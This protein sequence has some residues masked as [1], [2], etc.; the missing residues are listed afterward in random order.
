MKRVKLTKLWKLSLALFISLASIG[1][2]INSMD[3][4][5]SE[6]FDINETITMNEESTQATITLDVSNIDEKYTIQSIQNPDGSVMDVVNDPSYMVKEN[7]L[8]TFVVSYIDTTSEE[9]EELI[10]NKEV[11]VT[12]IGVDEQKEEM[13]TT[14]K[15]ESKQPK[16]VTNPS[17][18]SLTVEF[19]KDGA[20]NV[21]WSDASQVDWNF[22][23]TEKVVIT[24]V[25]SGKG[26]DKVREIDIDIP[27][28]YQIIG[29]SAKS[30][31]TSQNGESILTTTE[32]VQQ[33]M[34]T[35]VLT[36]QNGGAF[37]S[38]KVDGYKTTSNVDYTEANKS[39]KI[40]YTFNSDADTVVL[41]LQLG[42]DKKLYD[43][44]DT[45]EEYSDAQGT[46]SEGTSNGKVLE[47]LKVTQTSGSQVL[48]E[49][50]NANVKKTIESM[51]LHTDGRQENIYIDDDGLS[52]NFKPYGKQIH[53]GNTVN[54]FNMMVDELVITYNYPEGAQFVGMPE[55]T[56]FSKAANMTY[57]DDPVSRTLTVTYTNF[58]A[59]GPIYDVVQPLFKLDGDVYGTD[60]I[61]NPTATFTS[62]MAT[63]VYG[64]ENYY[65]T[66]SSFVTNLIDKDVPLT[67]VGYDQKVYDYKLN[68]YEDGYQFLGNYSV[69]N[70]S[71]VNKEDIDLE[72][73]FDSS[74]GIRIVRLALPTGTKISDVKI[75]TTKSPSGI[76]LADMKSINSTTG[77]G[78]IIDADKLG[79]DNDDYIT[80]VEGVIDSY[81]AQANNNVAWAMK[82]FGYCAYGSIQNGSGGSHTLT[83]D[84]VTATSNITT[85]PDRI[86]NGGPV[87][88]NTLKG[89]YYPGDSISVQTK[90]TTY[91]NT[92]NRSK[93]V[94]DDFL[95]DPNVY[96]RVPEGFSLD[97]TSLKLTWNNTDVTD[98][99]TLV[100]KY[101]DTNDGATVYKYSFTD[102]FSVMVGVQTKG[103]SAGYNDNINLTVDFNLKVSVNNQGTAAIPLRDIVMVEGK[104]NFVG[105]DGHQNY[106]RT[107]DFGL[108]ST[109]NNLMA[110]DTTRTITVVK[111]P[112]L[113]VSSGIRVKD[114]GNSFSTY[115]GSDSSIAGLSRSKKAEIEI[116]YF[117]NAPNTFG[118]ASIY[119]P[120]PKE[121]K[122]YGKYFN[123]KA[124]SDPI[125]NPDS[126][127]F[128]W[129]A[130][131]T[132]EISIPGFTTYYATDGSENTT[133]NDGTADW[134]AFE[135][136][137]GW[138]TYAQVSSNLDKVVFVKF[139]ANNPITSGATGSFTFELEVAADS[140]VDEINYWRT[141][142]S[143]IAQGSTTPSWVVGS[144]LA[145]SP[146][147]GEISGLVFYDN[148]ANG[149]YDIG[150]DA[151]YT[152]SDLTINLTEK[153]G[154]ISTTPLTINSDGTYSIEQLKEGDYTI[155]AINSDSGNYHFSK[156]TAST[157]SVIG[158]NV[159]ANATHTEGKYTGMIVKAGDTETYTNVGIG[160]VSKIDTN[161]EFEER[162]M[163]DLT[164]SGK[165]KIVIS[166]TQIEHNGTLINNAF[167]QETFSITPNV[168]LPEGMS[169]VGW[170]LYSV[171]GS[172]V[173]TKIGDVISN[174]DLKDT[175]IPS[176]ANGSSLL[177]KAV[178]SYGPIIDASNLT[179]YVGDSVNL[180]DGVTATNESGSSI[181]L[182]TGVLGN[183]EVN[184][185]IP[186]AGNEY[187]TAGTYEVTY[188]VKDITTGSSSTKVR[189]VKVHEAPTV[190]ATH[191]EYFISDTT[192][193]SSVLADPSAT[194]KEAQATVGSTPLVHTINGPATT[195]GGA[196]KIK[197]E[198]SGPSTDF[199]VTGEYEVTYTATDTN[200]K[201]G[202]K[203][204]DVLI[205]SDNAKQYDKLTIDA[206]GFTVKNADA[207]DLT[208]TIVKSST[209]AGVVAYQKTVDES[210]NVTGYTNITSDVTIKASQLREIQD[211]PISGGIY[212]LTFTIEKDDKTVS[213]TVK[214]VV[215]GT[216]TPEPEPTPD[217]DELA[218]SAT[219][220]VLENS[221]AALQN[222]VSVITKGNATA[223]LVKAGNEISN[224]T[225]DSTQLA[226][227][228]SVNEGGGIF[229]LTYT[230]EDQG[231][232]ISTTVKVIVK[233]IVTPE[234]KPTP[235]GDKLA[236]TAN[237]FIIENADASSLSTTDAKTNSNVV[238]YLIN[239]KT[240]ITDITVDTAQLDAI[241]AAPEQGGFYELTFTAKDQGVTN[242]TTVMVI[243]RGTSTPD[244]I[245][246][247][248]GDKLAITAEGFRIKNVD[249]AKLTSVA[250]ITKGNA[251]STLVKSGKPITDITVDGTQL[252]VIQAAP[253][254]GGIYDL[255]YTARDQGKTIT[256]TI[257]VVVE[258]INT[259]EPIP[260]P[261]GDELA[262]TAEGFTIENADASSLS[263]TTAKTNSNV[264]SVLVKAGTNITDI[265]VKTSDMDAIK[266]APASGGIYDLT[267][268]AKEQGKEISTTVKVVVKGTTTPEPKPTPDGDELAISAQG[269]TITNVEAKILTDSSAINNGI[270]S[271]WLVKSG[272]PI[273]NLKVDATQLTAIHNVGVAG[274]IY[275]LTYTAEDQGVTIT[276]TIKVVV[277]GVTTPEPVPTPDGDELAITAKGFTI[278][279]AA[280]SGLDATVSITNGTASAWLVNAGT[281]VSDLSVDTA[282]L[283]AINAAGK[284]GGIYDLTYTAK[285]QGV[286]ITTTV[287]VVVKGTTTPDPKPTPDG[288]KLAISAKGFILENSEASGLDNASSKTK[289]Q[290]E[291]WLVTAKTAITDITA[292][293]SDL[294]KIQNAP[295]SGGIYD[296]AYTAKDQGIDITSTVKVVVKGTTTPEPVPT[297]DG[298]KLA[299]TAQGYILENSDA[300]SL[301][302]GTA[303]T[304][305]SAKAYLVKTGTAITNIT[306]DAT[307]LATINS[308]GSAGGIYDLT[309]TAE[310]QGVVISTTVKVVV[311][312]I[313]TPEPTPTPGDDILAITAN[314]FVIENV[315]ASSLTDT[316]AITTASAEA[317]LVKANSQVTNISVDQKELKA[318]QNAPK[319]GGVYLLTYT[320][321]DQGVSVSTTVN[322]LVLPAKGDPIGRVA[323]DASGYV[324][325]YEEAL[326]LTQEQS[327]KDG[328]AI[329]YEVIVDI[330]GKI[331]DIQ[332]IS[333][334][335]DKVQLAEINA[336]SIDGGEFKLKYSTTNGI[337]TAEIEV[338]VLVN[339]KDSEIDKDTNVVLRAQGFV[340]E[341]S[342]ASLLNT[343]KAISSANGNA[344]AYRVDYTDGEVTGRTDLSD[345]VT[346]NTDDLKAIQSAPVTGGIYELKFTV[347]DGGI[348]VNKTVKV[349]VKPLGSVSDSSESVTI[350]ANGFTLEYDVAA[351]LTD[352]DSK[353][354]G[355]ALAYKVE[356][357]DDGVITD[358]KL[359]T[360]EI[361]V[362]QTELKAI[363]SAPTQG[364]IY[365]LTY[366][367][368]DG[369]NKASITVKV[370]VKPKHMIEEDVL[371]LG[372]NGFTIKNKDAVSLD[373]ATAILQ[374]NGNASAFKYV[375]DAS[376]NLIGYSDITSKITV[377]AKELE[378]INK[379]PKEG[380][381]YNLTFYVTDTVKKDGKDV[382]VTLEKTVKVVVEGTTTPPVVATP[383]GDELAIHAD[384][385]TIKYT[386]ANTLDDTQATVLSNV[387][388]WLVKAGTP[389][390]VSVNVEELEVIQKTPKTGGVYDLTFYTQVEVDGKVVKN[391]VTIKVTVIPE[392]ETTGKPSTAPTTNGTNTQTTGNGVDTGDMTNMNLYLGFAFVSLSY[393]VFRRK[394]KGAKES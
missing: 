323:I 376:G 337:D 294:T 121:G 197:I 285:N 280:A 59:S 279:N 284:E 196:N 52:P 377:D 276:T 152:G 322:V 54:T 86:I 45:R 271:A 25:F 133:A 56:T 299:I 224:I 379:A 266:A 296:L 302:D 233:G 131:L 75:Y 273:T 306:V 12:Q 311:K 127:P 326:A 5:A 94:T 214:V 109:G 134:E 188:K 11:E 382:E 39:G 225:V 76:S 297:P 26:N 147:I 364:G 82:T 393:L 361:T 85:T 173:K 346:I 64:N 154:K 347:K 179:K 183:T 148:N 227:I 220:F 144:V 177:A 100:S 130:N 200:G 28:G 83:I 178:V 193:M 104:G 90:F 17:G 218:I 234:P 240:N 22:Y 7:G 335:V 58:V 277:R 101:V 166:G 217:G 157:S 318:I 143:A 163:N 295:K 301:T 202:S 238:A 174:S 212:D 19:E 241:K 189:I 30:G 184:H 61:K 55:D 132:G 186:I 29:Y 270:A 371:V 389:T 303:I 257:K 95:Q 213:I 204:V 307:Q 192:I 375:Y 1:T 153:D 16:T 383:D 315:D 199:S 47:D 46:V 344:L 128:T 391:Q 137:S 388:A 216:T 370:F 275:D 272:K 352:A 264:K 232:T 334:T 10:Y 312:G 13:K 70:P 161:Y 237:G 124:L 394:N 368:E 365:D 170:Q 265:T 309:Y 351:T 50:T 165:A 6:E 350:Y 343:E 291:A 78:A 236:I 57:V 244:P 338:T 328:K 160:L 51:Y 310:D 304:N 105:Y 102:E 340:L 113:Q 159:T 211:A 41:T 269:F 141:Y 317:W 259:P 203:T 99:A 138:K 349:L 80:K 242:S 360:K 359:A 77:E 42:I 385:F 8:Y 390:E 262:I 357:D 107:D 320:A 48:E 158:S 354:K 367:I 114:S 87:T 332:T 164:L 168:V 251:L 319:A 333:V 329:G 325:S 256:T 287:K 387:E 358:I 97:E 308:V 243:V 106:I 250:A 60:G 142:S 313:N 327:I 392:E 149:K 125:N 245:P 339:P 172:N 206:Q 356:Y 151:I 40:K 35:S 79:L 263:D 118:T 23:G 67:I 167:P 49:T 281:N 2:L 115:D 373:A 136:A 14:D 18:D 386:Q 146:S 103:D 139:V 290:V 222:D 283:A 72:W 91:I 43:Y 120:I 249:A 81:T 324:L 3:L 110:P 36:S 21:D 209:H 73:T 363:N 135:P 88:T 162:V 93:Q 381:I 231:I 293:A 253:E 286:S 20:A 260:T 84:G 190:T 140:P 345:K 155:S 171:D 369:T 9:V 66:N 53:Y 201:T 24:A 298:D 247:P 180:L 278:E 126:A 31:T 321:E 169:F 374:E 314:G 44:S 129:S 342:E 15:V 96:I 380:G 355:T 268:T 89:A 223:V 215:E 228:K 210:D 198:I 33:A 255:T 181:T 289:G 182:I 37:G 261:D 384:D 123:N 119:F 366:T 185:S 258:G 219:S 267:F 378:V 362:D 112:E 316:K 341:N 175:A 230:A 254:G 176:V 71:Y 226:A 239:A 300:V 221:E 252:A 288:D 62:T 74:L 116:S 187:T 4:L 63:K 282:Q 353:T 98:E 246:T 68:G 34:E 122:D 117:N 92:Y 38:E 331:I 27:D 150:I 195:K 248:D 305:G 191:Q 208:E 229:D 336:T 194:W 292:K 274:G 32:E 111:L 235:D 108:T 205:L 207:K 65:I 156:T 372:A 145:A 330:T 69:T 348:T